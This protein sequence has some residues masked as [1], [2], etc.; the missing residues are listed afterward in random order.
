MAGMLL[1]TEMD[2]QAAGPTVLSG[3]PSFPS[4]SWALFCRP[5]LEASYF[6]E[7]ILCFSPCPQM[8]GSETTTVLGFLLKKRFSP[9]GLT[10]L[11]DELAENKWVLKLC[12]A[13][14]VPETQ[15]ASL[16][17]R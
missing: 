3:L 15:Q 11:D 14:T 7:Q 10:D 6:F 8:Q 4:P 1:S 5:A 9:Q 12:P 13:C 16:W 2:G 17:S